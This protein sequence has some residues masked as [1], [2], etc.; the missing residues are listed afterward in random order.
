M[1]LYSIIQIR[2]SI[3][4]GG[5]MNKGIVLWVV[6]LLV[7]VSFTSISGNQINNQIVKTSEKGSILYVGGSGPGNYTKIQDAINDANNGDT[8]FVYDDSSPY[9]ENILIDKSIN[10]I[11]EDRYTTKIYHGGED[12]YVINISADFVHINGFT[13]RTGGFNR[14][15]YGGISIY[16]SNN[17]IMGNNFIDNN[18]GIYIITS[19]NNIIKNNHFTGHWDCIYLDSSEDNTIINN[20]LDDNGHGIILFYSHNNTFFDNRLYNDAMC[21]TLYLYTSNNNTIK[22]NTIFRCQGISIRFSNNN[23]ITRNIV[24]YCRSGVM[25]WNVS[26]NKIMCNSFISCRDYGI[27]ISN[28]AYFNEDQMINLRD[29]NCEY[30]QN[31]DHPF[32][33]DK[34]WYFV[35]GNNTFYHNNLINNLKNAYDTCNDTWDDGY[36]SGGNYWDDYNG[37]DSDGDGIGDTQSPITGG[38]NEDRYPIMEPFDTGLPV[39]NFTIQ[40]DSEIGIVTF[41]GSLSYDSDGEIVSY[42]WDY[43]DGTTGTGKYGWHQY[44]VIGTYDVTLTVTDNDGLKDILT[45]SVDVTLA[46]IPPP[47]TEIDGPTTGKA[48]T[49]YEYTFRVSYVP[50]DVDLFLFVDW[51][52]GTSTGWIFIVEP[53][54]PVYL[55]HS[56][57][58]DGL[59]TIRAKAKDY[60]REG[61]WDLLEVTIPRNKAV[62]NYMIFRLFERFSLLQRLMEV[63]RPFIL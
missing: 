16:S 14:Y 20:T 8:V 29:L 50:E 52:D 47:D 18:C 3:K 40:N 57:S 15:W 30:N 45:K 4:E 17:I 59:Y 54:D 10:L 51:G 58:E 46:N 19:N 39:A 37:T 38:H 11:G 28:R 35:H 2:N 41:D 62:T 44:C 13:I 24:Y 26:H 31:C 7:M 5:F 63:W 12:Y 48:G 36:P 43:G 21:T 32:I 23:T 9:N 60:C 49:E 56:W 53:F 1:F 61:P 27:V 22:N 6:F 33:E 34:M 25:L 42:E 55:S